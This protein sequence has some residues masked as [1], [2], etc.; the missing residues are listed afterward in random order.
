MRHE[1]RRGD[2]L[3]A[4]PFMKD[5][6]FKRTVVLLTEHNEEGSF[7]LVLNRPS[8][9][10]VNNMLHGFPKFRAQMFIGG[11]VGM[12]RLNFL[13][14]YGEIIPN[15]QH[16]VDNLFWNGDYE[17]LKQGIAEKRIMPHN[18]KFFVGYSGWGPEQ[19]D[20]EMDERSWIISRGYR[21]IFRNPEAMW[22]DILT[23]MGGKYKLVA[24]YP[25]DPS[26]N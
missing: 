17:A 21:P 4:E 10:G 11:P 16:V 25:E 13:H 20:D 3:I 2:I 7:G 19:V 18:I 26:L 23:K 1:I 6:N 12:D 8:L 9:F 24:N 22:R 15:S 5:P 14:S